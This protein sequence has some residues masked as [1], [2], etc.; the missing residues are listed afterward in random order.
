MNARGGDIRRLTKDGTDNSHPHWSTDGSRITTPAADRRDPRKEKDD[1]FS[2]KPDGSDLK[3]LT[4]CNSICTYAH[5]S[6]D[7]K[8][9]VYRKVTN[10]PGLNWD[11]SEASRN[12]EVFVA[13]V[14][15]SE[16]VNLTNNAAFDGWPTW[17]PDGGSIAF[18]SN[19]GGPENRGQVYIVRP[20]GTGLRRASAPPGSY[21]QPAW[22]PD[23][24]K[25]YAYSNT[26]IGDLEWGD[27][28]VFDVESP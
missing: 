4:H 27:V 19:R 16:E 24:R 23:G 3:R 9:I 13:N 10:T 1:I 21:V 28:V 18:A 17:S 7:M 26:E 20:D 6:P 8:R 5:Y 2:M 11:L 12:S 25:I 22:S 14:D 15:G